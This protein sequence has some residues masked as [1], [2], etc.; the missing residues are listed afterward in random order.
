MTYWYVVHTQP[1]G[2]E[3][4]RLNLERQGFDVYLP[5]YLKNMRSCQNLG[6]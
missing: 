2:E 1:H 6:I 5:E 4:A 3:R